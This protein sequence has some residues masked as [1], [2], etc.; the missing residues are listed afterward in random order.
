[1]LVIVRDNKEKHEDVTNPPIDKGVFESPFKGKTAVEC[2][3]VLD[4]IRN[5]TGSEL[6]HWYFVVMD[7]QSKE[8][9][10]VLLVG[11]EEG[12]GD[13]I[14]VCTVRTYFRGANAHLASLSIGHIGWDEVQ[15]H[16]E[17]GGD[18]P[19]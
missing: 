5:E 13:K 9:G 6:N 19:S 3:H 10:S 12:E 15:E 16:F 18:R 11:Y 1:M 8:D 2:Y 17:Q 7:Q 4:S 14:S